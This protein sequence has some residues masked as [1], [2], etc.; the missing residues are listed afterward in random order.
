[1][2]R[3]MLL[4]PTASYRAPDFMSA[5]GKLGLDIVV[6]S[7]IEQPLADM[8][9]G[10]WLSLPY[11]DAER[12]AAAVARYADRFPLDAVIAVDDPGT[13]LAARAAEELLLPA[14]TAAA[15][16]GTRD[17]SILRERLAAGGLPSP[18]W[19]VLR[20][21][22]D[23]AAAAAEIEYPVVVKPLGLNGSRGVIRADD[24]ASFLRAAERLRRLLAVP[25]VRDECAD[26]ADRFMVEGF[27]G[28]DEVA[29]E[30]LLRDSELF[31]LA[32]FDK[33]YP[34]DGPY[35]EETIYVTPSRLPEPVQ[36]DV[37]TSVREAA[38]ALGLTDGPV[39]AELR[40]NGEGV[41]PL[42]VAARTIGGKCARTLSFGSGMSLEEIVL[43]HATGQPLETLNRERQAAG[44]M[45]M[46]IVGKGRLRAIRGVEEAR[47]IPGI[48]DIELEARPGDDLLPLPE[49]A[50]YPGFI[51][52]KAATPEEAESALREAWSRIA[53]D[54]S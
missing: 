37:I 42:D 35:F 22:D 30:G 8:Y 18:A 44:V 4:I 51:F 14:N 45:M 13:L 27:I 12:G 15:V 43:R 3:V 1:M 23:L 5:A 9:P 16:L 52:A 47:E 17:K 53:F 21:D 54:V 32:I 20:F 31:P 19:R 24:A 2:T 10:R 11:R 48:V 41:W 7:D 6:A 40:V 49:G 29:V 34:L 28:G 36:D 38:A 50:N 33:P 46:P 26:S 25:Q 39:H